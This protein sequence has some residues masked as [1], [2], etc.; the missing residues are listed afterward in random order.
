MKYIKHKGAKLFPIGIGTWGIGGYAERDPKNNDKEQIDALIYMF[1]KG[2][3]IAEVNLW[4]SEGKSV[5]LVVKAF[6][7]SEVKRTDFFLHQAIYHYNHST[8]QSALSEVLKV[9]ELFGT[10]YV[11]SVEFNAASY[12]KYGYG[13]LVDGLHS[14]LDKK[15]TRFIGV[16]NASLD[17]L[18]RIHEEFG[19]A[20]F[21]HEI[22]FNFEIRANED[23][24][25]TKFA[26]ENGILNIIYQPL[27]RNRTAKRNWPLLDELSK[28]YGKTQNQI[29]IN[30]IVSKGFLLLIKSQRI[31]YIDENIEAL[32]FEIDKSDLSRID[33]F[34]PEGWKTPK[35]DWNK[36]GSGVSIDQLSNIF[37]EIYDASH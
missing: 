11:D 9:S 17:L 22:G 1:R 14:L 5:E 35:I 18:K 30:W 27:R 6:K 31:K 23:L 4:N 13:K 16:T 7:E 25:I 37:D 10:D 34:R 36:T 29:I 2:L 15:R 28:K 26:Q 12:E 24:G 20:V 8:L 33:K 19:N 21:G 32:D 3:N